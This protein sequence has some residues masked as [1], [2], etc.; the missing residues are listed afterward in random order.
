VRGAY[1]AA[2][3]HVERVT[4]ALRAAGDDALADLL[5][6]ETRA[7]AALLVALTSDDTGPAEMANALAAYQARRVDV[8]GAL[9]SAAQLQVGHR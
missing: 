5:T 9:S 2:A 6:E 3:A 4:T 8:D 1:A 7:G